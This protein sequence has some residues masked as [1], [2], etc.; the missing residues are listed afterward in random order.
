MNLEPIP[1]TPE[2]PQPLMRPLPPAERYPVEALGPLRAAVEA[3]H[4]S[5]Q[6]PIA[7]PAQSALAVASLAV[8]A[9]A[10]V[11]TLADYAPL[12]L[13]ALT[14]AQSGE[15]K[16]T[17]DRLLLSAIR[18]H[19]KEDMA[20]WRETK[21][22]ADINRDVWKADYDKRLAAAK[23][24]KAADKAAARADLEA[25][26]PE[27]ATPASPERIVTE[28][29]FEGLTKLFE[30][31]QPSLGIMSDE[32]G[33]FLGGHAL[34]AE[35]R[36]KTLA[37]LNG[38]W[39]GD[40]I[41]RTRRG[42]GSVI[43]YGRRL[44]MHLMVQP[45][46]ADAFLADNLAGGTGFLPRFLI[47]RPASTVGTRMQATGRH[48][49]A[50]IDAYNARIRDLLRRPPTMDEASRELLPR[51]LR[52]SRDAKALLS[53]FADTVEALQAPGGQLAHITGYASKAA[54]QAARIAG[55]LTLFANPD[56]PEVTE[57]TMGDGII[58]A[59]HYLGEALRLADAAMISVETKRA[60][61]LRRWLA[62]DWPSRAWEL[63]RDPRVILPRDVAQ[64]GPNALRE[65]KVARE[66]LKVLAAADWIVAL[67][68][69][70]VVDGASRKEAYRIQ[71][72][73]V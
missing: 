42:D 3:V 69:G 40:P 57:A 9:H 24:A 64:W 65:T 29:T 18:E 53:E 37:A 35:N 67:P 45:V 16:S 13:Y 41:R 26:G 30:E 52:L 48:D 25:L 12:S 68:K 20:D 11:E 23:N 72:G 60:D 15:R 33:Q 27:P 22:S 58:L 62:D 46:V 47:S 39:G 66:A 14:V 28:P 4:R 31:G 36:Q 49:T 10:D 73:A 61:D 38:L 70:E 63:A 43:L 59:Q 34:N 71:C 8:Q 32:G 19:E 17:C 6:A 7:I 51:E 54:E 44:A 56:A 21:R 50:P 5:T 1:F 55:V 2:A